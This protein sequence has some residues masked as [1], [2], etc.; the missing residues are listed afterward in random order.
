MIKA[1]KPS[2]TKDEHLADPMGQ[3][4]NNCDPIA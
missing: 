3:N 1:S 4:Q 2:E